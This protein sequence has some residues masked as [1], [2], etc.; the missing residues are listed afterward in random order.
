MARI[1]PLRHDVSI[2]L[3]F[4]GNNFVLQKWEIP[5]SDITL[6]DEES[7]GG[8]GVF[9]YVLKAKYTGTKFPEYTG[10]IV[11]AKQLNQ[12]AVRDEALNRFADIALS[13]SYRD[14]TLVHV[15]GIE[16][17]E[18]S[19]YIVME[20]MQSSVRKRLREVDSFRKKY[21]K[22]FAKAVAAGLTFLHTRDPPQPHGRLSSSNVLFNHGSGNDDVCDIKL[23]DCYFRELIS[24]TSVS[25]KYYIAPE[26]K[27]SKKPTLKGDIYSFGVLLA[28]MYTNKENPTSPDG[29]RTLAKTE[30]TDLK[31]LIAQCTDKSEA[32][33][34]TIQEVNEMLEKLMD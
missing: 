5:S 32:K 6:C 18:A 7:L 1:L 23:D 11:V 21:V 29:K 24:H 34:P 15:L 13:D 8:N 31:N 12:K 27:T 19:P 25:G 14:K 4:S 26:I 17:S 30:W 28:E 2:D 9:T 16:W 20:H 3:F 10:K 22:I 33:R